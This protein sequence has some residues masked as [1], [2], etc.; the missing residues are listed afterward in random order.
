MNTGK[1]LTIT[2]LLPLL[3][4]FLLTTHGCDLSLPLPSDV[5]SG[6]KDSQPD[7]NNDDLDGSK[8]KPRILECPELNGTGTNPGPGSGS[9]FMFLQIDGEIGS[10][11][12]NPSLETTGWANLILKPNLIQR[13]TFLNCPEQIS[14]G[15]VVFDDESGE[16]TSIDEVIFQR[17]IDYACGDTIKIVFSFPCSIAIELQ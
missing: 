2:V 13:L 9:V 11:R 12:Y 17:S 7:G 6:I 4:C 14:L 8:G 3:I 15:N 10:I 1:E 16:T 5:D